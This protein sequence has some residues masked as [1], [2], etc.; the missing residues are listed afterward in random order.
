MIFIPG[1]V[2]SSKNSRMWTGKISIASPATQKYR[3]SSYVHWEEYRDIFKKE[4]EDKEYPLIIGFHFVRKTRHK[5]DFV[6]P[7]QC[8]QDQMVSHG[9]IE[10]DN[11]DILI[12]KPFT[13]NKEWYSYD[14]KEPGVY[15]KI[16]DR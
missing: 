12:P 13:L 6:N 1:N 14:K 8:V 5:F 16:Y 11:S 10:D 9:W 7:L 15:I 4:V 3:K 2:P